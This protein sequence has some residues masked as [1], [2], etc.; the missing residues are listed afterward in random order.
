[1]SYL[2]NEIS[3]FRKKLNEH[4]RAHKNHLISVIEK[5]RE[6]MFEIATYVNRAKKRLRNFIALKIATN[7]K[8]L[9]NIKKNQQFELT[10]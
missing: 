8:L 10:S 6:K 9:R 4:F 1:M 2:K 5:L 7:F 3:L